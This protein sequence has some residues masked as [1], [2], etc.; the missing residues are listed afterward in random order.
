MRPGNPSRD[1]TRKARIPRNKQ[2]KRPNGRPVL[3]LSSHLRMR[4]EEKPLTIPYTR[5]VLL[6][7][8]GPSFPFG[9]TEGV[10]GERFDVM[11][12]RSWR[13]RV[14]GATVHRAGTPG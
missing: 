7:S 14:L 11:S 10:E 6:G 4:E 12:V 9:S 13:E 8:T 3:P 2:S 5:S 1:R